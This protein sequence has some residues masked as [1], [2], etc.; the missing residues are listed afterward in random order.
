MVS[1]IRYQSFKKIDLRGRVHFVFLLAMVLAFAV[2]F[3]DPPRT[4]L[5]IFLAYACS[6][7]ITAIWRLGDNK[8]DQT[9]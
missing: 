2:V 3:M 1:N 7:P 4:L 5:M 8:S 6:G 9:V